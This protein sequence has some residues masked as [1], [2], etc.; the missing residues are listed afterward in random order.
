MTK[1]VEIC[2][3]NCTKEFKINKRRCYCF[4]V[5]PKIVNK[6]AQRG[7]IA[8]AGRVIHFLRSP[9]ARLAGS[10]CAQSTFNKCL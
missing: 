7:Q 5:S 3:K 2:T 1:N 4:C 10:Y 9:T 8:Y 6:I